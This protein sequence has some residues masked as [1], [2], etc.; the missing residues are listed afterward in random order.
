MRS[1]SIISIITALT[2][3]SRMLA[4]YNTNFINYSNTGRSVGVN[5]D[6]EAGSNGIRNEMINQLIMGGKIGKSV[7]DR[8]LSTMRAV[9]NFGINLN[10]DLST[11]IKGGPKHD[12]LIGI[13]N[14][15][16]INATI[17]RDFYKLMF[18]GNEPFR[19]DVANLKNCNINALRFQEIKFG[20]I[21][22]KVD[23]VGKIGISISFLKGEQLFFIQTHNKS[24]LYTAPDG[25][26]LV[27]NSNF[28]MAI[29]DTGNRDILSFNGIGGSADIFFETPYKSKLGKRS[30][31]VVNANNIG[32]IHWRNNS[33]QFS[34]DSSLH[35]SGY[36]IRSITDLRDSTIKR[37]D[38]D[39]LFKHLTNARKENFNVLIPA[40]LVIINKIWFGDEKWSLAMGYRNIF[41]ANYIAYVFLEPGYNTGKHGYALHCGYGGY[42]RLN[43]GASYTYNS[44]QWF[45]RIGSNGLQGFLFPRY[46]YG[47]S[48]FLSV[49]R[50]LN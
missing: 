42:G 10:Y 43:V 38:A 26:E 8:S 11:F 48:A 19:G 5:L 35:F 41:N 32:F 31:L 47:Q 34:S 4:Q 18:Y 37:I 23:S 9:S 29:S 33:V 13:K 24:T 16:V 2:V 22:H 44:K 1:A 50:K 28:N 21:M 6:F 12:F 17:T 46:T 25:S 39:S 45:L 14:Q 27:F 40:N 7:K 30:V 49:A 20:A 15:E 3:C 36:S